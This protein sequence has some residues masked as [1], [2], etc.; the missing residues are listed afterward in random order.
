ME[1]PIRDAKFDL[2]EVLGMFLATADA[3]GDEWAKAKLKTY[4]NG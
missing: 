2:L 1:K 4:P 3:G